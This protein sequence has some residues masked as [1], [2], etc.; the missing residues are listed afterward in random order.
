MATRATGIISLRATPSIARTLPS[1]AKRPQQAPP[2]TPRRRSKRS[3][4]VRLATP[5][6]KACIGGAMS[7][8]LQ[9]MTG[10]ARAAGEVPGLAYLV[11]IKTVNARGLDMRMRFTPGYDAL[12]PEIRRRVSKAVSRGSVTVN[13]NIDREGEGGPVVVNRQALETVLA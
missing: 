10:Y 4:R 6:N 2:T 11:E 12:E 1:T 8:P 7:P 5:R 13:L 3:R 9:S